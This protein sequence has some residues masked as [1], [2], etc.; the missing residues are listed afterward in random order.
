VALPVV[1]RRTK[2]AGSVSFGGI[3]LPKTKSLQ[4]SASRT[5]FPVQ[6]HIEVAEVDAVTPRKS[7][8]ISLMLNRGSQQLSNF[9]IIKYERVTAQ[10]PLAY[11][12]R[13]FQRP[14]QRP[15]PVRAGQRDYSSRNATG[16]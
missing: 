2:A 10:A 11:D 7:A 12:G 5:S 8:L 6:N 14:R 3:D 9:V 13:N 4:K 1:L 15:R 16:L